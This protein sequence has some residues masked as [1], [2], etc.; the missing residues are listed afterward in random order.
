MQEHEN[1]TEEVAFSSPKHAVHESQGRGE[2]GVLGEFLAERLQHTDTKS[3]VI[4]K[5]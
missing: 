5:M 2:L 4:T 1:H 3:K